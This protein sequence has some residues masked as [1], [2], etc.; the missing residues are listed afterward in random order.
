MKMSTV[1][2]ASLLL[3]VVTLC[4]L[5]VPSCFLSLMP[6]TEPVSPLDRGEE[7]RGSEDPTGKRG[8]GLEGLL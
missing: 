1:V 4:S 2:L 6:L 5:T 8:R 7:Q 3:L